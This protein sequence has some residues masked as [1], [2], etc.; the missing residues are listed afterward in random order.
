M[1]QK[2]DD[3]RLTL[4]RAVMRVPSMIRVALARE[5]ESREHAVRV[6]QIVCQLHSDVLE[7]FGEREAEDM[8]GASLR[9]VRDR[10]TD[11]FGPDAWNEVRTAEP[12][13]GRAGVSWEALGLQ[14]RQ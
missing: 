6:G 8:V 12:P 5:D 1:R 2:D 3:P 7:E 10:V 14:M 13:R 11:I 4:R 9:L